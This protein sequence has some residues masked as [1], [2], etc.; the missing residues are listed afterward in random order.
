MQVAK[1]SGC[2]DP[3]I[4]ISVGGLPSK[5]CFV[6]RGGPRSTLLCLGSGRGTVD[7]FTV[8]G[9]SSC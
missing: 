1:D 2:G 6:A 4:L 9:D 3:G 8:P 7:L 5:D